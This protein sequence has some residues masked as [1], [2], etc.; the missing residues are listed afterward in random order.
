LA[1]LFVSLGYLSMQGG[2]REGMDAEDAPAVP[3][4]TD[5]NPADIAMIKKKELPKVAAEAFKKRTEGFGF[6]KLLKK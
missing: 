1:V 6:E 3:P 5:A 2:T 4:E